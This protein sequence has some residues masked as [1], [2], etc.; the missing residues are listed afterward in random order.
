[1]QGMAI[2]RQGFEELAEGMSMHNGATPDGQFVVGLFTDMDGRG[3]G[4]IADRGAFAPVEVP[5]SASTAIWDVNPSRVMVGEFTDSAGKVRGFYYDGQAF[6]SV[7]VSGARATR[8]RG[9]NAGGDLV[10]AFVDAAGRTHGFLA[11][12]VAD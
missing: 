12:W 11:Q 10:G 6:G 5:G 3:K 7:D 1:M 8:L 2:T 9:I 4:Y